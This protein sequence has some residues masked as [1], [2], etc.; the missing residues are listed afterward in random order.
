[1]PS[2]PPVAGSPTL[3]AVARRAARGEE[4]QA[5]VELVALLPLVGV[6]AAL[7][8]QVL[9]AGAALWFGGTA[10]RAAARAEALG[11]DPVSAARGALPGRYERGLRV[12]RE[13]DGGV[14]V[15]VLVPTVFGDR[16]LGSVTTRAHFEAQR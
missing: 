9:L 3:V 5:A 13:N 12:R 7:V 8:W 15:V 6:L 4:G 16:S 1:M 14:A 2:S 11:A 10:A